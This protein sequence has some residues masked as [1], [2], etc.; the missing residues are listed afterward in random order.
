[1]P[2]EIVTLPTLTGSMNN[3]NFLL[4]DSDTGQ[5]ALVDAP[6]DDGIAAALKHRGWGLDA[7]LLTHH[8]WDHIDGAAALSSEFG[9]TDH[10]RLPKTRIACR[11]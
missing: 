7:I 1:M 9:A 5:T 6:E 3:Y 4:H 11:P 8:H 2:L 10:R